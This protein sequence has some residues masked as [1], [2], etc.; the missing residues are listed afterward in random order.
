MSIHPFLCVFMYWKAGLLVPLIVYGLIVPR[1]A[2]RAYDIPKRNAVFFYGA[3]YAS[4][5]FVQLQALVRQ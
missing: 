3:V 1:A 2:I 4:F 5:F